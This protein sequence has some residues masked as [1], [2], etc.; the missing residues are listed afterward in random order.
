MPVFSQLYECILYVKAVF[1]KSF[2]LWSIGGVSILD[3][4]NCALLNQYVVR[5]TC[6]SGMQM[7][8]MNVFIT[9]ILQFQVL[10]RL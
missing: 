8:N 10:S 6:R 5:S 3:D 4:Y 2:W 9:S 1:W 7:L